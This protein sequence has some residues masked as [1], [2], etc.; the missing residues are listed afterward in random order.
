MT[1]RLVV[2]PHSRK[3]FFIFSFRSAALSSASQDTT[4]LHG[5]WGTECLNTRFPLPTPVYAGYSVKLKKNMKDFVI[6]YKN[7]IVYV[8]VVNSNFGLVFILTI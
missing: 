7:L 2:D 8:T 3:C 6:S 5:K 1:V 4:E